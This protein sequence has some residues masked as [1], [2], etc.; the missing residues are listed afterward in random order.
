M[1]YATNPIDGVRTYFADLH[2]DGPPILVFN[3]L[4]DLIEDS[5]ELPIVRALAGENRLI[6]IDHRGHGRS[7]KPHDEASYALSTRVADAIAA[8][9]ALGIARAHVLGFSWGARLGFAIGEHAPERVLSLILCGNQPYAWDRSW[10][11]VPMLTEAFDVSRGRGMQGF[12]DVIESVLGGGHIH[13]PARGRLLAGDHLALGAAWRSAMTEGPISADLGSW[14][15]LCLI[16][17]GEYDEMIDAARRAALEIPTARFLSLRGHSHLSAPLEVDQV[18][19][20][21]LDLLRETS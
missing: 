14:R 16:Y 15:V 19:P 9:D 11:F 1:P 5:L 4:G 8:L 13:D 10:S 2:G 12:I 17:A 6:L 20:A 18:L 7:D 3:G 21:V